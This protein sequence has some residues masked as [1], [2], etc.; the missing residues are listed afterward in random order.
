MKSSDPTL[1]LSSLQADHEEADTRMILHCIHAQQESVMVYSRDTD[2]LVLLLAHFSKMRCQFL[3]MNAGTSKQPKFIPVHEIHDQL[4]S[5]QTSAIT[6]FHALT[7]CD[8]VSQISGH[9]KKTTW[10]VFLRHHSLLENLGKGNLTPDTM[11]T[12]EKFICHLYEVPELDSCDQARVKLFCSGKAQEVLPPTSDAVQFHIMRSHYQASVWH[13]AHIQ[14][15]ILPPPTEMGW[16]LK[17]GQLVPKLLSLP[18]IPKACAEITTC[19]CR[20]GCLSKLCSCRKMQLPCVEACRCHKDSA[21]QN[22][23]LENA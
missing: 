17:N 16:E 22:V 8:T 10:K 3:W 9:S 5:D 11:K 14:Y 4:T 15:P 6:G 18:A 20:K 19:G 12:A 23:S 2:V 1:D 21:C 13:Q 7:G